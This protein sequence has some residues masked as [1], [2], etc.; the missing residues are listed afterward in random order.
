V[1]RKKPVIWA[2]KTAKLNKCVPF[3]PVKYGEPLQREKG[4]CK[5]GRKFQRSSPGGGAVPEK[6]G[7]WN[8]QISRGGEKGGVGDRQN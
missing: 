3:F 7:G 2:N 1:G 4:V 5:G 6:G 8:Y